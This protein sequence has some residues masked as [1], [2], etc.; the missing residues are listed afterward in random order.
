MRT[1]SPDARRRQL[2]DAATNVFASRGFRAAGVSD[3]V[4]R[5]GVARG[6]FYL[7][8]ESKAQ[9]FLAIVEDFHDRVA[10]LLEQMASAPP[11]DGEAA[12]TRAFGAWLEFF[13]A[14]RDA[15][16]VVLREARTI[17]PRFDRGVAELRQ[18]AASFFASRI[19][20]LQGEGVVRAD[21]SPEFVA[22]AQLG[23]LEEMVHAYVL[24]DAGADLEAIANQLAALE[25]RGI[26]FLHHGR[27]RLAA[28]DNSP[29]C[30]TSS[31]FSPER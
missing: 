22:H 23:L 12:L 4:A 25:W 10:D 19:R 28:C 18:S 1:L 11:L 9:I 21:V 14:N 8:F 20:A 31:D 17:D 7:H 16:L 27:T 24:T 5:A 3:I 2:L 13:A 26:A 30:P 29:P 6:T 15:A